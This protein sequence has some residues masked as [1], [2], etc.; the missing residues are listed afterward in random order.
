M[1]SELVVF[2]TERE[3]GLV[4]C[5]YQ[6][7]AKERTRFFLVCLCSEIFLL[8]LFFVQYSKLFEAFE[9]CFFLFSLEF[10]IC[11]AVFSFGLSSFEF[12]CV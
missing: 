6:A 11:I 9:I 2:H 7:F 5:L 12:F 10:R 3:R 8:L 4:N 1:F